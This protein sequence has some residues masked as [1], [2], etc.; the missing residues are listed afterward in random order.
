VYGTLGSDPCNGE[1]IERVA[2]GL[3]VE[4]NRVSG[5]DVSSHTLLWSSAK[6]QSS[7]ELPV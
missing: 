1:K 4:A 7:R 2:L 6:V 5:R 3:L